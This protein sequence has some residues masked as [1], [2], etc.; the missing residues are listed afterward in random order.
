MV[1]KKKMCTKNLQ[2]KPLI[3]VIEF[4]DFVHLPVFKKNTTSPKLG[5]LPSSGLPCLTPENG[6]RSS[7]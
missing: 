6:I 2:I 4:L 5:L 7:F 3:G 1:A